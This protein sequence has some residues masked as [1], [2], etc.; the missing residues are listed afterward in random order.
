V[1][2]SGKAPSATYHDGAATTL[3]KE[4]VMQSFR[5]RYNTI[6]SAGGQ[7]ILFAADKIR[8]V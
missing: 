8:F 1:K 6:T 2:R 5:V 3:L 4:I 7:A